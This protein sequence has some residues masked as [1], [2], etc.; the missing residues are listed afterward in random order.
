MMPTYP[1]ARLL[2]LLST[3]C[4]L[5]AACATPAGS[6]RVNVTEVQDDASPHILCILAHPDDETVFA[7]T[8]YKTAT[9]LGGACDIL[10]I[11]NGEG[12]FKYSTLAERIYDLE[13]TDE[14]IGEGFAR[15]VVR[16]VQQARKEADLDVSDSIRLVLQLDD[17]WRL[18]VAPFRDYIAEQTLASALDL[19]GDPGAKDLFAHEASFGEVHVRIGLARVG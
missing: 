15:D 1:E 9:H 6:A 16:A 3:A 13:L 12:G 14:L 19:D 11:T 17:K 18:A 10:L 2:R 4:H 7:G 8:L 5:A